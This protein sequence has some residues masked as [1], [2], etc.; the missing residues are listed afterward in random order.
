MALEN[1]CFIHCYKLSL[2]FEIMLDYST[3]FALESFKYYERRKLPLRIQFQRTCLI[4]VRRSAS[5]I[6]CRCSDHPHDLLFYYCCCCCCSMCYPPAAG[7][8]HWYSAVARCCST[9]QP[10]QNYVQTCWLTFVRRKWLF[11]LQ[12]SSRLALAYAL[13]LC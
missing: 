12:R 7:L 10:Q 6:H 4:V 3:I 2:L 8:V 1:R 11:L 13:L 5:R 9:T